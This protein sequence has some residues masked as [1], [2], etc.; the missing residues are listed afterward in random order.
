MRRAGFVIDY[1][2]MHLVG[3][4]LFA[5]G[6]KSAETFLCPLKI[7]EPLIRNQD[8]V[9][10]EVRVFRGLPSNHRE[11][12][13]YSLNLSQK[14]FWEKNQAVSVHHVP[15][16]YRSKNLPPQEKGVDVLAAV[17]LFAMSESGDFDVLYLLSHDTD[18][19][20]AIQLIL[21]LGRTKI[22][23]VGWRGRQ[24]LRVA[25]EYFEYFSLTRED[26]W[27]AVMH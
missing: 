14:S 1:Q 26:Y 16:K 11:S 3:N 23:S 22:I 17:N 7:S 21:E 25:H 12:K 9:I 15:L 20:P 6:I 8:A 19:V 10:S 18:F 13:K 24:P 2:N 27:N 5:Q 4:T